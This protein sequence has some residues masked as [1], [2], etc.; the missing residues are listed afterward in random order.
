MLTDAI[1]GLLPAAFGV[2]LSPIPIVAVILMLGTPRARSNGPAF[3]V[4]WVLGLVAVSVIVLLVAGGA[5]QTGSDASDSVN[6][7]TLLLGLALFMMAG[8]QW[9]SRP[10]R[11]EQ[12]TMPKWMSAIDRVD[13]PRAFVLGIALSGA[14]PKNLALTAAAAGSIAQAGLG[15]TDSAIAV[16]VFVA[17]GSLTVV[18]PVLFYLLGGDHATKPL[19]TMEQF[20]ADHSNVIMMVLLVIIGAKLVGDGLAGVTH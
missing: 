12:P 1:G 14:N 18:G 8:R 10:K 2:A 16:A 3:A 17:I 15:T 19:A 6:W 11:G 9:R 20:M 7:V 5:N 4:G 13:P